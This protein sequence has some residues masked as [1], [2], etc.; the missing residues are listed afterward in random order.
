MIG[1]DDQVQGNEGTYFFMPP[2]AL[3]KES[4]KSGYNGKLAD[5]WSLGVTFFCCT[6]LELPFLGLNLVDLFEVI[7]AKE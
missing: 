5:I 7:K 4:S 2:E 3:N 6:F 1:D